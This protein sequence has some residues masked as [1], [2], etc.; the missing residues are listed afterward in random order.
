MVLYT[1]LL[2]EMPSIMANNE[3]ITG[4]GYVDKLHEDWEIKK[5]PPTIYATEVEAQ[6]DLD[7]NIHPAYRDYYEIREFPLK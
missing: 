4:Y 5:N 3:L 6:K 2:T 7:T 1:E